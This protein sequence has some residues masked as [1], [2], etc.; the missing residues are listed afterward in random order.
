MKMP[1][2]EFAS[3]FKIGKDN[4]IFKIL[5]SMAMIH[6]HPIYTLESSNTLLISWD[7]PFKFGSNAIRI[8]IHNKTFDDKLF[9]THDILNAS[10]VHKV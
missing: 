10:Q 1:H 3:F 6:K 4:N 9:G 7:Y 2:R 8:R 5:K